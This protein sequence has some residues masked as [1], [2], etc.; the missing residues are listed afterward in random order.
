[1]LILMGKLK[2]TIDVALRYYVEIL[3]RVFGTKKWM[4]RDSV[5]SATAL[6]TVI[7]EIVARHCGRADARMIETEVEP[8]ECKV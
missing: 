5:F 7:G 2:L 3:G 8:D 4:S 1:M 6:E